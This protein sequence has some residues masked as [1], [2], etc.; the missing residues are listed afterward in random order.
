MRLPAAIFLAM[1][2]VASP[3]HADPA[4]DALTEVAK[5]ADVTDAAERLKCYDR[6]APL[7]RD[8]LAPAAKAATEKKSF[9]DWFG[10]SKPATPQ[11]ADEYGKPAPSPMPEEIK[12]ITA[13]VLEFARTPH[14]E[15]LFIL[16]NGQVWKQLPGDTSIVR[17]P[18]PGAPMTVTIENGFLGSY[19]LT[20][21]WQKGL[22]KVTRLK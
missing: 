14:G 12:G 4:L 10:F 19:N 9:F 22:V 18:V 8:A 6:V 17:D 3:A 20:T 7:A 11:T 2:L 13:S 5:C 15:A 21:D 1:L 16:A